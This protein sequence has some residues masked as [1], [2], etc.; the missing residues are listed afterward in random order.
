MSTETTGAAPQ[1]GEATGVTTPQ[2]GTPE[3]QARDA[4]D[5]NIGKLNMEWKDK[6][7]N[8]NKIETLM[9][10]YGVSSIDELNERLARSPA[11][12]DESVQ[13]G[14]IASDD[15]ISEAKGWAKKGDATS[16][17]T[18]KALE[19][20]EKLEAENQRLVRGIEDAF[21]VRDI[22]DAAKRKRVVDHFTKNRHRLGDIRAAQA[23]VEVADNRAE[24][25]RLQA[26]LARHRKSG[27]TPN[28]PATHVPDSPPSKTTNTKQMKQSE[29]RAEI[30]RLREAGDH[31]GV[32]AMQ[33]KRRLFEVTV[34]PG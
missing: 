8:W 12:Q 22:P 25:E 17:L 7:A 3:G 30:E 19:K 21:T 6:A 26:E 14:P 16:R 27:V 13:D 2:D 34:V 31:E 18:L 29:F 23:E 1:D 4:Q 10:A 11:A 9:N 33:R 28:A 5:E 24:I 32:M 15:E 20:I